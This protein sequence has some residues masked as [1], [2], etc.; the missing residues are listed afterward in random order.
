MSSVF[1]VVTDLSFFVADE[2]YR[3]DLH[4]TQG[5]RARYHTVLPLT[6]DGFPSAGLKSR[7]EVVRTP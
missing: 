1:T 3:T 7:E 5:C 2:Y 4:R 6:D